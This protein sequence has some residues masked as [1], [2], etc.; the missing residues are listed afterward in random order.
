MI[1]SGKRVWLAH[2]RWLAPVCLMAVATTAAP[3]AA[4]DTVVSAGLTVRV[5]SGSF[6]SDQTTRLVYAPAV[7]RVDAGRFEVAGYFPY[8]TIDNGTVALSQ[9]GFVPM[10]GT[11][12]SVPTVGMSMPQEPGMSHRQAQAPSGVGVTPPSNGG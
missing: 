4:Q 3:A 6:G 11:V 1:R 10:R 7:L 5:I 12:M 9:G 2:R 8:L